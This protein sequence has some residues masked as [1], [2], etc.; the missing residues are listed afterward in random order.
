M[1]TSSPSKLGHSR[2][3]TALIHGLSATE[4]ERLS[5]AAVEAK[6]KAYCTSKRVNMIA[7]CCFAFLPARLE[8]WVL[9][10]AGEGLKEKR[11]KK[12]SSSSTWKKRFFTRGFERFRSFGA[13]LGAR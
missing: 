3:D 9:L 6:A 8:R 10:F 11:G 4:V 5:T 7:L 13:L 2:R 12:S 1:T